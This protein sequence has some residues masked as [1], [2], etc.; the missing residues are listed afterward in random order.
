MKLLCAATWALLC[1]ALG[2]ISL[3]KAVMDGVAN[4]LATGAVVSR[5]IIYVWIPCFSLSPTRLFVN[6]VAGEFGR[7]RFARTPS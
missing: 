4:L 6:I 1:S 7:V 3:R 2:R 5:G